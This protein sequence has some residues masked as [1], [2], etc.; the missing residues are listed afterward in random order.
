MNGTT[1]FLQHDFQ[2]GVLGKLDHEH[3]GL[4]SDVARVWGT[5][6]RDI[7]PALERGTGSQVG[8]AGPSASRFASLGRSK[9]T[10]RPSRGDE[11]LGGWILEEERAD[12]QLLYSTGT[13]WLTRDRI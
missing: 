12:T 1:K 3:A 7:G 5:Y 10:P 2:R 9:S 6:R 4:H 8:L 13:K 11:G